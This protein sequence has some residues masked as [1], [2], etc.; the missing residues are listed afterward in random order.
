[1]PQPTPTPALAECPICRLAA[2][3]EQTKCDEHVVQ[4]EHCGTFAMT[5]LAK[6]LVLSLPANF[7]VALQQAIRSHTHAVNTVCITLHNIGRLIAP[8][9]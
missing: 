9:L 6:V 2:L 1:M 3:T 8:H 5:D 4:C 7:H